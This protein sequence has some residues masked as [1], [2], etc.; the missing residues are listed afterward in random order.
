MARTHSRARIGVKK[1]SLPSHAEALEAKPAV[2]KKHAPRV[3]D[4][5]AKIIEDIK[6]LAEVEKEMKA[7]CSPAKFTHGL[8]P[9]QIAFFKNVLQ[10][11]E[12]MME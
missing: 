1:S 12:K 8:L 3:R 5:A 2:M 4:L 6:A 9:Q 10:Q 7:E 11:A